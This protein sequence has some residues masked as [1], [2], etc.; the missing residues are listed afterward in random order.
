MLQEIATAIPR[1]WQVYTERK[2]DFGP[3]DFAAWRSERQKITSI[4]ELERL[5]I[6]STKKLT[7][8]MRSVKEEDLTL[9]VKLPFP[10]EHNYADALAYACWNS[11]YHEGRIMTIS[12]LL[13]AE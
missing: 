13:G 12:L 9:P 3:H 6:E 4:D 10:G 11:S 7:D 1:F 5:A 2:L 8:F